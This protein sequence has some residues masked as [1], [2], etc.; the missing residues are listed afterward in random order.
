MRSGFTFKGR[1]T[2]E[3]DLTVKTKARPIRSEIKEYTYDA[4][5]ADGEVDM[6]DA[7]LYKRVFYKNR[8][9]EYEM[10]TSAPSLAEL[11]RKISRIGAWLTGKGDLIF[12]DMPAVIWKAK[13]IDQISYTPEIYGCKAAMEVA[14]KV[15]PFSVGAVDVSGGVKLGDMVR[16]GE[17]LPLDTTQYYTINVPYS[18]YVNTTLINAGTWYMRPVIR[19]TSA[20]TF[21]Q[22]YFINTDTGDKLMYVSDNN[23]ISGAVFDCERQTAVDSSGNSIMGYI[24]GTF[25]EFPPGETGIRIMTHDQASAVTVNIEYVPRFVYNSDFEHITWR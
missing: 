18:G 3:F 2:S 8:I 13:V 22:L 17:N 7:N 16:L 21:K 19:V 4:P 15:P 14:F 23:N 24:S 11:Q 6:S 10:Q 20:G 1:H 25:L 9:F 12:D 5:A